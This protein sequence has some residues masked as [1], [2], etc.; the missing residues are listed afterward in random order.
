MS[1]RKKFIFF[2]LLFGLWQSLV[3]GDDNHERVF[4]YDGTQGY[5]F[6]SSYNLH[7]LSESNDLQ[8]DMIS[9]YNMKNSIYKDHPWFMKIHYLQLKFEFEGSQK[10]VKIFKTFDK[11]YE[12]K[13]L[14]AIQ[15]SIWYPALVKIA[16]NIGQNCCGKNVKNSTVCSKQLNNTTSNLIDIQSLQNY[17]LHSTCDLDSHRKK[18]ENPKR[19][20]IDVKEEMYLGKKTVIATV[21]F[22]KKKSH[23]SQSTSFMKFVKT[24]N[25]LKAISLVGTKRSSIWYPTIKKEVQKSISRY[26]K[27]KRTHNKVTTSIPARNVDPT[28]IRQPSSQ[29]QLQNDDEILIPHCSIKR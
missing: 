24:K 6:T 5:L 17:K 4:I 9:E 3:I 14:D 20:N 19:L 16:E 22:Q 29:P 10:T 25:G 1:F 21:T 23:I 12:I 26:L 11:G 15:Q 7:A 2:T 27:L 8:V 28:L 18:I 13:G